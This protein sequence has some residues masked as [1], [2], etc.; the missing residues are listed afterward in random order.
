MKTTFFEVEEILK[1]NADKRIDNYMLGESDCPT[2]RTRITGDTPTPFLLL[3]FPLFS[4]LHRHFHV[5]RHLPLRAIS[6]LTVLSVSRF[7][8]SD[9]KRNWMVKLLSPEGKMLNH[10]FFFSPLY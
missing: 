4:F 7:M 3:L 6:I 5:S 9:V 1:I 10:F 2:V 8:S